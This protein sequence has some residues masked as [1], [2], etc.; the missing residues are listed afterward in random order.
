MLDLSA[1]A[2]AELVEKVAN[3]DVPAL[4][5]LYDRYVRQC[6]GLALRMVNEPALAEEVVQEV[7]TKFWTKPGNYSPDKG[8]FASWLLSLVHH[9]CIDELRRK[10]RTT[11]SLEHPEAGNVLDREPSK[12]KGLD[13]QAIQ[14]EER[15]VVRQALNEIA[16]NQRQV[17]ELAYFKGLSQSEIATMLGQPLGT[18]KTRTRQGLKQLKELV[19]AK[20]LIAEKGP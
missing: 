17:I 20:G 1:I 7:F 18:V 3:G 10:S 11:I 8:K 12:D 9:R 4:E 13:D 15:T 16:P 2:D 14:S 6:F 19:A 5:T